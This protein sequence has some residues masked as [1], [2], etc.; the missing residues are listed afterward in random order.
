MWSRY[1]AT[2]VASKGRWFLHWNFHQQGYP[3]NHL[4]WEFLYGVCGLA[5]TAGIAMKF[6]TAH[7]RSRLGVGGA[8]CIGSYGRKGVPPAPH[9]FGT[10]KQKIPPPPLPTFRGQY[11]SFT[12]SLFVARTNSY[13]TVAKTKFRFHRLQC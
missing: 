3:L 7:G 9:I 13:R 8:K 2:P 10:S 1:S 4:T 6:G 12:R 11:T 5:V